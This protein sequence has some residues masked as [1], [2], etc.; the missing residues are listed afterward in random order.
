MKSLSHVRFFVTPWTVACQAPPSMG[1]SRQEYWVAISFCRGSSWPRVRTRVS[2]TEGRH[3]TIWATRETQIFHYS[4][5]NIPQPPF[6]CSDKM[7]IPSLMFFLGLPLDSVPSAPALLTEGYSHLF[8]GLGLWPTFFF[9][10]PT[11]LLNT[12]DVLGLPS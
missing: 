10:W 2:C 12:Y 9:F 3:L 8:A 7:S 1:F 6:S 5:H 11:Y 4:S